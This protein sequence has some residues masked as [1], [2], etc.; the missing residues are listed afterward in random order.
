MAVAVILAGHYGG[1]AH[2]CGCGG[3]AQWSDFGNILEVEPKEFA[4]GLHM[5]FET[6]DKDNSVVWRKQLEG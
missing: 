4:N 6:G 1:L 3:G 2:G 5:G